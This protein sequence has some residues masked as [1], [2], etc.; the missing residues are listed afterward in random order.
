MQAKSVVRIVVYAGRVR[1][2]IEQKLGGMN[3]RAGWHLID[4]CAKEVVEPYEHL[5]DLESSG[6]AR[7]EVGSEVSERPIAC[8]G[9]FLPDL[10]V[11]G[12]GVSVQALP[13]CGD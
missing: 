3:R 4:A 1:W 2:C 10:R 13:E 7:V 11:A 8:V 12:A 5:A 6:G 9:R